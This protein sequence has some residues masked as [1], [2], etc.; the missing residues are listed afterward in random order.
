MTQRLFNSIDDAGYL[1]KLKS[2]F[3][4]L[5]FVACSITSLAGPTPSPAPATL[6]TKFP[7]ILLT[8]GIVIVQARIDHHF[9]TLNF[10][11]DTG[12]GGISLDSTTVQDLQLPVTPSNRTVR[13]I[14]G[15]KT[16]SF[17][18]NKNLLLPKLLVDSLNFHIIDYSLL[19]SVYGMKIDGIIGY[20]FLSRYIVKLNYDTHILE[21][22]QPGA[23]KYPRRG[24]VLNP[25]ISNI[26]IFYAAVA[27]AVNVESRFYFD[28]GGGLCLLLSER[29]A[30]DSSILVKN[31]RVHR[32][33]A[34]GMGGKQ[35]M[36]LTTVK[37]VKV[38]PYRFRKV[39]TYILDDEFNITS[40]PQLGGLIGNDLL[41]R[42]NTIIN[43]KERVIHMSPNSHFAE[44]F[45]YSYTGLGI[46]LVN[47]QVVVEDVIEGSPGQ[48]AGF[49][50]GDIVVSV[51]N[52]LSGNIQAYKNM[53]QVPG[54]RIKFVVMRNAELK[55]LHLKVAN[56][57]AR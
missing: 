24:Y 10:I 27:D 17:V 6:I 29:F 8:G 20:S 25:Y 42:F 41:R 47:G 35:A 44:P 40:Y 32:T 14:A 19:T 2:I 46:Y 7:F 31:K 56:I 53:L 11:L 34:E 50:P 57:L 30:K 21:V 4:A 16:V 49:Q 51:G 39:P 52:N 36:L 28:T 18:M 12:S 54:A 37:E 22:W 5:L 15:I 33:Q 55:V 13:G 48:R 26:P 45:D 1:K 3:I 43:Y 9:D 38:G 23:I